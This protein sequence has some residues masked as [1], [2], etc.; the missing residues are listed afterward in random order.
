[1]RR[2][3]KPPSQLSESLKKSINEGPEKWSSSLLN[4]IDQLFQYM[5]DRKD[6]RIGRLSV[7]NFQDSVDNILALH[8]TFSQLF[9][10]APDYFQAK[11][12]DIREDDAYSFLA[13]LL[14]AW[15]LNPPETT[16]RDIIHYLKVEREKKRHNILKQLQEAVAPLKE[17][18]I[19]ILLPKDTYI[20]RHVTYL[21]LAFCVEDPCFFDNEF[22]AV[23]GAVVKAKDIATFFY[24]I[25]IHQGNRFLEGGYKIGPIQIANFEKR[26]PL[27]WETFFPLKLPDGVMSCLPHL[28]FL[29]PQR[30]K[31]RSTMILLMETISL[32]SEHEKKL[33]PLKSSRN[34]FQI[35]LYDRHKSRLLKMKRE[36]GTVA[37][38]AKK[39]MKMEFP[40]Q[41]DE[42]DFKIVLGFL[43]LVEDAS[44]IGKFEESSLSSRS[45]LEE[46]I[47]SLNRFL[48]SSNLL[49]SAS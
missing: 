38:D 11:E 33:E 8:S 49:R 25:P 13:D 1:L 31:L 16:Q 4:F 39:N 27:N 5:K 28:P 2:L 18:G 35:E 10:I 47:K 37:S 17:K 21:P 14:D 9:E 7:I 20:S 40:L 32:L 46:I 6:L 23:L 43:N 34:R 22:A 29:L 24:L 42:T 45:N 41:D 12:L 3:P 15:I 30:L 36:L 48:R 44:E 19:T 26:V